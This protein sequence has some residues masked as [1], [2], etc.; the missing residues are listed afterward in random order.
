M[1]FS[2]LHK[3]YPNINII[4]EQEVANNLIK[5]IPFIHVLHGNNFE[6]IL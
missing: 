5:K 6:I 2:W 4:V 3:E 1:Q